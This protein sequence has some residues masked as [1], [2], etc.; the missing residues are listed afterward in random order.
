LRQLGLPQDQEA[1]VLSGNFLREIAAP[2]PW[3]RAPAVT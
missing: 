2:R 3:G 1:A